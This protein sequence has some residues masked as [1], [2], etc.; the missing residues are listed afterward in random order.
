MEFRLNKVDPEVRQ[1]VNDLTSSSR[2]HNKKEDTVIDK[3][4][5]ENK[6]QSNEKFKEELEKVQKGTKKKLA[7]EAVKIESM[8]IT[9]FRD[10]D[11][12]QKENVLGSIIDTRK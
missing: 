11:S 1:R 4:K 8:K 7:V 3:D 6:N 9:A 10:E 12:K 5:K 2:I